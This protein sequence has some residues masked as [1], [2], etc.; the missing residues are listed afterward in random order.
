M[1]PHFLSEM[2][3]PLIELREQRQEIVQVQFARS[4][5]LP[6]F[7]GHDLLYYLFRRLL[8]PVLSIHHA[9]I[10]IMTT[11]IAVVAVI[12][13]IVQRPLRPHV[14][15]QHFDGWLRE[16]DGPERFILP[17]EKQPYL[18]GVGGRTMR[19]KLRD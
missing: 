10:V 13:V 19:T 8:L 4:F 11:F 9:V 5:V 6:S 7:H 12:I 15:V 3:T 16:E 1:F 17:V 14:L 2:N 18:R